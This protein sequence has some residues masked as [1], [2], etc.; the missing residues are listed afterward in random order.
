MA[1]PSFDLQSHSVH[2]DGEL[3]PAE[4]VRLAA[5]AGL[6]LFAL[7]D[8]DTVDGVA[9]A[10]AAGVEHG[11]PIV[12]ATEISALRSPDEDVHILGYAI[13]PEDPGLLGRLGEWRA[14]RELR[15]E[16]MADR[17]EELGLGVD[18]S[19]IAAR[20]EAG[21]TVGRPHLAAG[22]LAVESNAQRLEAEGIDDVGPFIAKYLIPG[23]AGYLPR[24][25]PTVQDAVEVIHGAGG[26]A[27]WA[28]PFWD[29]DSP[30]EVL[31]EIDR[32]RAMGIDGVETFYASHTEQ[33][34][35][36]LHERCAALGLLQ[37][38]SSDFHG[39]D[40]KLFSKFADFELF[41]LEPMLGPIG[42]VSR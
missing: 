31:S 18:R 15:A 33:Q 12:T 20:R 30:E 6:E 41:G 19:G 42:S 27:I 5:Q 40:H 26:V 22:V 3:A 28:H 21:Q 34:T 25:T 17:L 38:G 8:H 23:G 37:T 14:D 24:T 35:R 10:L 16:R 13:D 36:L 32:F 4:V 9:E 2:S 7:S 1:A 39:P 11:L 29:L